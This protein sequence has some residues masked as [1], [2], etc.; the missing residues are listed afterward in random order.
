MSFATPLKK[1]DISHNPELEEFRC[2]AYVQEIN[3]IANTKLKVVDVRFCYYLKTLD[4]SHLK[5]L[6]SFLAINCSELQKVCLSAE[7]VAKIDTNSL[8]YIGN[9]SRNIWQKDSWT[10][11]DKC[12]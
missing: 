4:L 12:N 9:Y 1:I 7:S 10:V 8:E 5:H 11:W 6:K 2:S 3:F